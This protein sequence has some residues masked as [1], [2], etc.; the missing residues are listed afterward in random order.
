MAILG[1]S[2]KQYV[3][4][5]INIRQDKLSLQ[6]KDDN[7]LKYITSKTSFLRLSSGVDID[8]EVAKNLGFSPYANYSSNRLA[9]EYVLF[10]SQFNN[11]FTSN[12]GY[13]SLYP[14]ASYGFTSDSNYGFTPPPGLLSAT[15]NTLNRGT[16]REATINLVCHNLYQFKIINALFLSRQI[17]NKIGY[18][19]IKLLTN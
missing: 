3:R 6:N 15:V 7:I 16:I 18:G 13:N 17:Y 4:D 1:E 9:Q 11:N 19:N 14:N 10:S 8:A 2:F 5:Q 12:I